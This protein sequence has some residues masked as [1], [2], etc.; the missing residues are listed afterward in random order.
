MKLF[1]IAITVCYLPKVAS[2]SSPV[3]PPACEESYGADVS[4]SIHHDRISI[5]YPFLPHNSDAETSSVPTEY[6]DEPIQPLGNRAKVFDEYMSG[7]E[8]FYNSSNA[9]IESDQYRVS[10]NFR[11]PSENV[12]Y[13]DTGYSKKRVPKELFDILKKFWD[14]NKENSSLEAFQHGYAF[15]NHWETPTQMVDINNSS[16][17]G[18]GR[19]L[20]KKIADYARETVEEWTHQKLRSTSVYGIRSYFRGSILTPHVDRKSLVSSVI[21]NVDQD[22][23]EPWPLEVYGRDGKAVN[24]TLE[25]GELI[26]YESHTLIHG[27]P[28]AFNGNYFA[29]IFV[30]FEP[31]DESPTDDLVTVAHAAA[32]DG[33]LDGLKQAFEEDESMLSQR[34][35]NGWMP[36]HY[37][38]RS[39]SIP[40][41]QF[42]I[43]NG[44][45]I[46]EMT[47]SEGGTA[48]YWASKQFSEHPILEFLAEN[49]GINIEV[50]GEKPDDLVT[51]AHD[52]ASQGNLDALKQAVEENEALLFQRDVNGWMPLHYAVRAGS[53]PVIQFLI[54]NGV[55]INEKSSAGVGTALYWAQQFHGDDENAI[56]DFI[57]KNGGISI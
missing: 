25:P 21:I 55:D 49:G 41:I 57:V 37:A 44:V 36:L 13:T 28:F 10:M 32:D 7:C 20:Y 40:I 42:L 48:L 30:H 35:V 26:L 8:R 33:N 17:I 51:I 31:V 53:I 45:D 15:I 50:P 46:N 1:V 5:N 6:K 38:A 9:C 19:L 43:D 2:Q 54:D 4:W 39:G 3:K 56:S 47:G 52:A 22:V 34:D 14:D 18:G 12:N 29:N 24:V 11:Q 16:N 23:D 27:R